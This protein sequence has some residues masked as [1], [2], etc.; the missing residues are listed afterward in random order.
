MS[1]MDDA[2]KKDRLGK[3]ANA[4]SL[5]RVERHVLICA[6]PTNPKCCQPEAGERAWAQLKKRLK[7]TGLDGGAAPWRG[8]LDVEAPETPLGDGRVHRTKVDCLRV[9]EQG[10]IAVVY[11][12][13]VWY[14][15]VTPDVVDRIVDEHLLGGRVVEDH[16]FAVEP[17]VGGKT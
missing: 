3:I 2:T 15:D 14:H 1:A 9:C 8:K 11:P 16:A 6:T 7:E 12:D 5:G 4:L 17:L 10:P 13:G